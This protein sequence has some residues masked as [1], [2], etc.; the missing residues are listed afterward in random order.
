MLKSKHVKLLDYNFSTL[1]TYYERET[2]KK[3]IKSARNQ[4][5]SHGNKFALLRISISLYPENFSFWKICHKNKQKLHS[6]FQIMHLNKCLKQM[7]SIRY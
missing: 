2:L 7:G 6:H 3:Y 5:M 1:Y 4:K